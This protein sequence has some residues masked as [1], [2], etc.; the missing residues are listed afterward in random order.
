MRKNREAILKIIQE[1]QEAIRSY[2]VRKLAL[3]G[4]CARNEG[5]DISDL[6][7][8]VE[9]E[10]KSF[11]A[12]MDLKTLLEELFQCRVDLVLVSAIKPR[13]RATIMREAVHA[14][15]L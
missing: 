10:A 6:D 4:S 11:D 12:Y 8:V 7:F 15:G 9:F 2:G 14:Q 5:T 13:L 3:F 1:H